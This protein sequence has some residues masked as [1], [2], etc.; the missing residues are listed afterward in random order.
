VLLLLFRMILNSAGA[1]SV[2][3]WEIQGEGISSSYEGQAVYTEGNI[4]TAKGSGFFFI[5][6]PDNQSDNNPQTSDAV[7]VEAPYF[8][9]V[10]DVVSVSGRVLENDGNTTIGGP[11]VMVETIAENAPL[12][13]AITLDENLPTG[14]PADLHSLERVENMRVQFTATA[15]SP[16]DDLERVSLSTAASRPL[17]EP[18]IRYPGL[19]ELPVWDG[20]PEI[21]WIDPNGLS[22]PNN[23]FINAGDQIE[24]TGVILEAD[25]DFWLALPDNYTLTNLSQLIPV[26]VPEEQ[27]VTVGSLNLLF[28]FSD[29][30][31]ID[32][33][34]DKLALYIKD[35]MRLPDILGV[36]EAGSQGV[37]E[38]L[39]YYIEL[40]APG[41]NYQAYLLPG[42]DDI[43]VGFLVKDFIQDCTVT[44]LGKNEVFSFGGALHDRPPLL[45]EANLPTTPATSIQVLNLHL[46]SLIGIEGSS[47]SFVRNKRHQQGIS[48]A[49]MVDELQNNG[50]LIIVGDFNAFEFTDGYV[51]VVNQ[52]SGTP[53]LGAQYSPFSIVSPP[54]MKPIESLP[55][56]ERYSY[57]YQGNAQAL[58]HCLIG[59]L[60]GLEF[61][62]MAYARGNAD[63]SIFFEDNQFVPQSSSDHDGLV[64]FLEA[65]NPISSTFTEKDS[66][67]LAIHYS[68]PATAGSLVTIHSRYA[69]SKQIQIFDALGR[70]VWQREL[71][72]KTTRAQFEI[73]AHLQRGNTYL[74]CVQ[75][76][77]DHFCDWVLLF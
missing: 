6:S 73:P 19:D 71:S 3:L 49:N 20:N 31:N 72:D 66:R 54:L 42:N 10:G 4:V 50:N 48:V 58:D 38:D 55:A 39:A 47:S 75:S 76:E 24:A 34:L 44:Q 77:S 57:V 60:N 12:P 61:T 1:Q 70:L 45:L 15:I 17:R 28:L 40:L 25:T 56:A 67:D 23:R 26:P 7:L 68:N 63:Y 36:Q 8:G 74:I 43:N 33:R 22:A 29:F 64:V 30:S 16:S 59:N 21:F 2:A 9:S 51:D 14:I 69:S 5:Q 18:G 53:T 32:L 65:E 11:D 62:R 41:T 35:Q 46:R 13:T 27:E 37:L 52:I